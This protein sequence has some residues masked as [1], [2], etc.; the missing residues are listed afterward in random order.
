VQYARKEHLRIALRIQICVRAAYVRIFPVYSSS[1]RLPYRVP[2]SA[3]LDT[4][5]QTTYS[6]NLH[7]SNCYKTEIGIHCIY[8]KT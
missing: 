5:S 4:N 3:M 6:K 1:A 7:A 8:S 2:Y